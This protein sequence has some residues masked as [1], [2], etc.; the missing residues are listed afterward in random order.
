MLLGQKKR[1][2]P[3]RLDWASLRLDISLAVAHA[4]DGRITG[5]SVDFKQRDR[6]EQKIRQL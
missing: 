6:L 4:Q 3:P 1:P 2:K 5:L